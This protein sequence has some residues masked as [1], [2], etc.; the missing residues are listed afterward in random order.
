MATKYVGDYSKQNSLDMTLN[1]FLAVDNDLG[2]DESNFTEKEIM[3][4][5]QNVI[6]DQQLDEDIDNVTTKKMREVLIPLEKL[7]GPFARYKNS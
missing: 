5:V 1:D 2:T 6:D 7:L 3:E 4:V